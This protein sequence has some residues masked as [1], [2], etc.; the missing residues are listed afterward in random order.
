MRCKRRPRRRWG[1]QA[2]GGRIL[3]HVAT[4]F[5][6]YGVLRVVPEDRKGCR[7]HGCRSGHNE[8]GEKVS[9]FWLPRHSERREKQ[10][11]AI[12]QQETGGFTFDPQKVHVCK[13]HFDERGIF[14]GS[15]WLIGVVRIPHDVL[16]KRSRARLPTKRR[17]EPSIE[18]ETVEAASTL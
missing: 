4:R 15:L 8:N 7:I 16:K 5:S 9:M 2:D 1:H 14:C 3:W 12:L 18:L 11:R 17:R 13:K 6:S 10:K